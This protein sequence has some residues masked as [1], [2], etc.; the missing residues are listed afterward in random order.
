M[1][2][3]LNQNSP[4]IV[5]N[6]SNQVQRGGTVKTG[7]SKHLPVGSTQ[8]PHIIVK[9]NVKNSEKYAQKAKNLIS[10][11]KKYYPYKIKK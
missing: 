5:L 8:Q 4:V 10:P 9:I 2:G 6:F 3:R 7:C 11:N 1:Y